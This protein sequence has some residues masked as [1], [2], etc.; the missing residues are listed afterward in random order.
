[1]PLLYLMHEKNIS[2]RPDPKSTGRHRIYPLPEILNA[3]FFYVIRSGCLWHLVPQDDF[4]PWRSLY[5]YFREF[6]LDGASER[7]HAALRQRVRVRLQEERRRNAEMKGGSAS[8]RSLT[9]VS[10]PHSALA[11]HHNA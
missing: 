3:I 5:H 4:P 8:L 1:M 10:N 11:S 2:N 9:D 7:M 6:H